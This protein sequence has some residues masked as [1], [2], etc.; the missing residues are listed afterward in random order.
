METEY[1][2]D[3]RM[4][5]KELFEKI[6]NMSDDEFEKYLKEGKNQEEKE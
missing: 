6:R 3:D 1:I 5:V 4:N 2:A